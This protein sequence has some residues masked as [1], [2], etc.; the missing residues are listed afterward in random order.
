MI[1]HEAKDKDLRITSAVSGA[2][3]GATS[4]ILGG[5][6]G[7][8]LG[9]LAGALFGTLGGLALDRRQR[10]L[11]AQDAD[12]DIDWAALIEPPREDDATMHERHHPPA[13][14]HYEYPP[15]FGGGS[16]FVRP[17]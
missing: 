12:H 8:G 1:R 15:T 17:F 11:D 14:L 4:G 5:A 3:V 10:R 6:L 2:L 9:G 7:V 13:H 16:L